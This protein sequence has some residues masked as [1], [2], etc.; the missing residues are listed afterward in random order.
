MKEMG[1]FKTSMQTLYYSFLLSPF[2]ATIALYVN[3]ISEM[4]DDEKSFFVM[5]TTAL[6]IDLIMGV[7][8]HLKLNQFS[9]RNL[10]LGLIVKVLVAYCGAVLFFSFAGLE[11]GWLAEWFKLV[12]KFTVLVYPTGSAVS[13]MYVITGG[14]F[15]PVSFMRKLDT[16]KEIVAIVEAEDKSEK[17]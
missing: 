4:F 2:F 7:M 6:I 1:L 14:R 17:V 15:P 16:F 10:V 8:K 5:L 3:P 13:N 11:D 9:F 12:A